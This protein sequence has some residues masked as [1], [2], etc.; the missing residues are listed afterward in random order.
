LEKLFRALWHRI[1]AKRI[2]PMVKQGEK[3]GKSSEGKG[4]SKPQ[5]SSHSLAA[6]KKKVASWRCTKENK[7]CRKEKRK[8]AKGSA[9]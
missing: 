7:H 9:I 4:L 2:K 6:V 1:K 5:K 8:N 3:E